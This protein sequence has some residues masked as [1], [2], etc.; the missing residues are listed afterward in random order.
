MDSTRF[1]Q[2]HSDGQVQ[3]TQVQDGPHPHASSPQAH[4]AG[5]QVHPAQQLFF[6][7]FCSMIVSP[8]ERIARWSMNADAPERK[9]LQSA[10]VVG[11]RSLFPSTVGQTIGLR[12]GQAG[13]GIAWGHLVCEKASRPERSSRGLHPT[14]ALP[15]KTTGIRIPVAVKTNG[16][17]IV[18]IVLWWKML[19]FRGDPRKLRS[20]VSS[21]STGTPKALRIGFF[22]P[23]ETRDG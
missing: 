11:R 2:L 22:A 17:R 20:S 13:T 12:G 4:A 15:H 1:Q 5:A 10:P 9:I 16:G 19:F 6:S 21:N 3:L 23:S 7:F 14:A 18:P 8:F